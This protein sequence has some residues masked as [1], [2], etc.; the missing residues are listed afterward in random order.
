MRPNIWPNILPL[1]SQPQSVV[2][3]R[4]PS[5]HD[6]KALTAEELVIGPRLLSGEEPGAGPGY[7][8]AAPMGAIWDIMRRR[9]AEAQSVPIDPTPT[10]EVLSADQIQ[11]LMNMF[12]YYAQMRSIWPQSTNQPRI[13]DST[14]T[15]SPG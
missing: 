10:N 9:S 1:F 8:A 4:G 11:H 13:V 5:K 6:P 12:V 7:W 15:T 3:D 2:I 14:K